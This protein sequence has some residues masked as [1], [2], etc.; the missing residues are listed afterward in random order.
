MN[1]PLWLVAGWWGLFAGAALILGAAVGYFTHLAPR[2]IAAIMAFGSGVLISALSFD[3]MDEAY[4]RGGFDSTAIGF[5]G[6]AAVYTAA[7]WFLDHR[8]AKHRKRSGDQQPN[9]SQSPGSGL[10]IA[11]GALLDGI[12]ESIVIGLSL[13]AGGAVSLVAVIAISLSNIP[14]GLSSAAGMKKGG[15]SAFYIFGVWG[16][17]RSFPASPPSPATPFFA[18]SRLM[19]S[20][21]RPRSRPGRF[22][23]CSPTP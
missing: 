5:L 15:R 17:T 8:G 18:I 23:R 1:L 19:S 4:K 10:A 16:G 14:E 12:P 11:V 21:A 20:P 7:N 13:L 9:E 6:G 22:S 3:L 2:L